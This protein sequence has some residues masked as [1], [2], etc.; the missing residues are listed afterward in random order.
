LQIIA[1]GR[2]RNQILSTVEIASKCG[3]AVSIS[4]ISRILSIEQEPEI[5][6]EIIDTDPY[7]AG[8]LRREKELVVIKGCEKLF[9]ERTSRE[10]ISKRYL[11]RAAAFAE[12]LGRRSSNVELMAVSGS[13][14]Y[15]SALAND[16]IDIF[17]I[18]KSNRTWL[19]FLKALLL[20][21]VYSIR[22]NVSGEKTNYCLSYVQDAKEFEQVLKQQR[23]PLFAREFLS[24]HVLVGGNYYA[25]LLHRNAWMGQI[26][27][28]L[29]ASK[30]IEISRIKPVAIENSIVSEAKDALN[31]FVFAFLKVFLSFK[32]FVR[33]LQYRKQQKTV[34]L[35]EARITKDSCVYTSNKYHQLETMYASIFDQGT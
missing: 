30:I 24:M 9:S 21:R 2:I 1:D 13:V 6:Q 10:I 28:G 31:I 12:D 23:T 25:Q 32:A 4:E 20:A 22:A 33:N 27:P 17:L 15:G 11:K 26:F 34:D 14:A 16:D 18:A 29:R 3:Q 35:F 19:C 8:F 7:F 5:I